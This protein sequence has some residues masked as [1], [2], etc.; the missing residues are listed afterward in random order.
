[1]NPRTRLLVIIALLLVA[2][3]PAATFVIG[4]RVAAETQALGAALA[5]WED[6]R[7]VRFEYERGFT[8]GLLHYDLAWTPTADTRL[9]PPPEVIRLAGTLEVRHGPWAGR[10]AGFALA[11]TRGEFM[12]PPAL[13]EYLPDHPGDAP[14][15]NLAGSLTLGG[16]LEALLSAVDYRG[17][18]GTAPGIEGSAMLELQGLAGRLRTTSRL[19][20]FAGSLR[21]GRL[22]IGMEADGELAVR[23]VAL[24]FDASQAR[25]RVWTG[26]STM[27]L[28][29]V[30]VDVPDTVLAIDAFEL[31]A[32]T[33]LEGQRLHSVT[34][35]N[36]G[37]MQYNGQRLLGGALTVAVR[38]VD[39]D[40]LAALAEAADLVRQADEAGGPEAGMARVAALLDELLAGRPS[41]VIDPWHVSVV[42]EAD[43]AARFAL[44]LAGEAV[45]S[46]ED[47]EGLARAL[48]VE[49]EL[50]MQ[51]GALRHLVALYVARES[52][53]DS[54]P[55]EI[56]AQ[57]E[58]LYQSL[59]VEL[60]ELPFASVD[61]LGVNASAEIRDGSL[62]IGGTPFMD[63]DMLLAMLLANLGTQA[64]D[65]GD[66]ELVPWA[67]P[68]FGR[69]VLEAGFE[70]DPVVV[71]I[72]AG[73]GDD[74]EELVGG[75]CVGWVNGAQPDVVLE[76]LA[77]PNP[78]YVYASAAADTTLAVL[79][80]HGRWHCN[81]DFPGRGLDPGIAFFEPASGEYNIWVGAL[82]G[83]T[84]A[85]L[86]F[87]SELGLHDL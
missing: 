80:P 5:A 57:A 15:L 4:Q 26:R 83:G 54:S 52:P 10:G 85:A 37:P 59:L 61:E 76:Y 47:I 13:Q 81:D 55:A 78:L 53:P 65:R 32:H 72:A 2:A 34:E 23:D 58:E 11:A 79:D 38:D 45:L 25:P 71:E 68:M 51:R 66:G 35:A 19:D 67:E 17:R 42:A 40:A 29:R 49:A 18:L 6:V 56:A 9:P 82:E 24:E 20:R 1:M 8:G 22:G 75:G 36:A 43:V 86:L 28:E 63:V 14:V 30:K 77:G 41:L 69:I 48:H 62:S 16:D 39:V 21:L 60:A 7:V 46:V 31:A 44:G 73:G 12:L 84:P 74:L 87:I 3:W 64:Q 50:K 70:P 27:S 33:W